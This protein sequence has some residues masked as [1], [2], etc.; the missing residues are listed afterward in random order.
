MH[1]IPRL[2]ELLANRL[3]CVKRK[4]PWFGPTASS[5]QALLSK[6]IHRVIHRLSTG[7]SDP[8]ANSGRAKR[9]T[10]SDPI[11]LFG[12]LHGNYLLKIVEPSNPHCRQPNFSERMRRTG[13]PA[14][15]PSWLLVQRCGRR[16]RCREIG[17]PGE[18]D[19]LADDELERAIVERLSALG[20]LPDAASDTRH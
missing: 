5:V 18:F 11:E 15:S 7:T 13:R 4:R 1:N 16:V 19:N 12:M 20:L 14:I 8:I 6:A 17:A 9:S 3:E 10:S 2:P